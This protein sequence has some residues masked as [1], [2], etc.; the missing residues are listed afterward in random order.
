MN[1]EAVQ[2]LKE[3]MEPP[4]WWT[5][6]ARPTAREVARRL[7][8]LGYT[9]ARASEVKATPRVAAEWDQAPRAG[10][11][12]T[13]D[14]PEPLPSADAQRDPLSALMSDLERSVAAA[15]ESNEQAGDAS[16]RRESA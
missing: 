4:S 6:S 1:D 3:A 11:A 2:V 15:H 7:E 9:V 13:T 5:N 16:H 8:E 14:E 10:Q 12:A